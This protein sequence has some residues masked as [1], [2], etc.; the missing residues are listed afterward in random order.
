M[1]PAFSGHRRRPTA[2]IVCGLEA[3][4][5]WWTLSMRRWPEVEIPIE[6]GRRIG[7]RNLLL[8]VG[9]DIPAVP[10]AHEGHVANLAAPYNARRLGDVRRRPVLGARKENPFR[11]AGSFHHGAPFANGQRERLLHVNVLAGFEA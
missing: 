9:R 6:A 11:A 1:S 4:M 8:N 10:H 5:I 7:V 2:E 3:P